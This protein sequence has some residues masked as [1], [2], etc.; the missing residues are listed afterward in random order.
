[1]LACVPIELRL[2]VRVQIRP[3]AANGHVSEADSRSAR[4]R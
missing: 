3:G 1:V 2:D 4:R